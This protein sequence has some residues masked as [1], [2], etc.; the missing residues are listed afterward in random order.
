M[1]LDLLDHAFGRLALVDAAKIERAGH[2]KSANDGGVSVGEMA[3]MVRAKNLPPAQGAAIGGRIAPEIAEVGG[4]FEIEV[5]GVGVCH[6][7]SLSHPVRRRNDV[8]V[9]GRSVPL[10]FI[11]YPQEG[12]DDLV[13]NDR[14]GCRGT[15]H[16][17]SS[18]FC[19]G[20]DVPDLS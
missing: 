12:R 18:V 4:A 20:D 14:G 3:E 7:Q 2:A 8:G 19:A 5:T 16:W 17:R 15:F 11:L 6:W 9:V 13:Q 1:D 10:C